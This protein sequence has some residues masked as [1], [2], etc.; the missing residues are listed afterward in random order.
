MTKSND[1]SVRAIDVFLEP[2]SYHFATGHRLR[3]AIAGA[4]KGNFMPVEDAAKRW[5]VHWGQELSS[6]V[7]LP[8][9]V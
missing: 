9:E 8:V 2:V 1:G 3:V 6:F 5:K 7:T 4:D